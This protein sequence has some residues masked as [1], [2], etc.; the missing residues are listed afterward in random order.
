MAKKKLRYKR[1]KYRNNR[2]PISSAQDRHH[3]FFMR[4]SYSKGELSTLRL[5][6]YCIVSIPRDTMHR[7]IHCEI[8]NI[9]V[10]SGLNARLALEQLYALEEYGAISWDDPIE[11]RLEVLI[12]LFEC[13]EQPTADALKRELKVVRRFNQKPSE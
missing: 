11:K 8:N 7:E 2:K 12:S 4:K 1:R 10:P 3:I 5:F 13:C 9:P 6:W